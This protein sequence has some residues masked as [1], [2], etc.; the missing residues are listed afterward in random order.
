M[1]DTGFWML[2]QPEPRNLQ[3]AIIVKISTFIRREI[4][5][6]QPSLIQLSGRISILNKGILTEFH[7]LTI[8]L[9]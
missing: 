8:P 7:R 6:K 1:L 9:Y 2:D 5:E 4:N 3:K